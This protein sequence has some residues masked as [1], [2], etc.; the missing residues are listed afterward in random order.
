VLINAERS[1]WF[2]EGFKE[3]EL[4]SLS[5]AEWETEEPFMW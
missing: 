3:K 4:F 1:K 2:Y 5:K